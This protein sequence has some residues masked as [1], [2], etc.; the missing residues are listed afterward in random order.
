M[1]RKVIQVVG[2]L[3]IFMLWTP[4]AWQY[5]AL[6]EK[7]GSG[8]SLFDLHWLDLLIVTACILCPICT[9]YEIGKMKDKDEK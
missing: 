4:L 3:W 9:V 5:S 2:A 6:T 7:H 8:W 1:I